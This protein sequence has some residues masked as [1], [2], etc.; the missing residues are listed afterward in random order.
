MLIG[1]TKKVCLSSTPSVY[2]SSTVATTHQ[3][4]FRWCLKGLERWYPWFNIL[5][6]CSAHEEKVM[7]RQFFFFGFWSVWLCDCRQ[8]KDTEKKRCGPVFCHHLSISFSP[9]TSDSSPY[10]HTKAGIADVRK[11]WSGNPDLEGSN[12]AWRMRMK[13]HSR[14]LSEQSGQGER[15][16]KQPLYSRV[17]TPQHV[18]SVMVEKRIHWG[19]WWIFL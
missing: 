10:T 4:C 15:W 13:Q 6:H 12:A 19:S 11:G 7:Y 18:H 8:Q 2:P 1:P 14:G 5:K 3:C 17:Q 9:A 16:K